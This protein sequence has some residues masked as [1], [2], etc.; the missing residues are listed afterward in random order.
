MREAIAPVAA[1]RRATICAT[2]KKED[3]SA[4]RKRREFTFVYKPKDGPVQ[5]EPLVPEVAG[6]RRRELIDALRGVIKQLESG[7]LPLGKNS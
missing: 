4:K 2:Q 3:A 5:A 7:D 1:A 6:R